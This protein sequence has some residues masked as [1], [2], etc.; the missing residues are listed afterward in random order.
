MSLNKKIRQIQ[1]IF[2]FT[3][4]KPFNLNMQGIHQNHIDEAISHESS[5][6]VGDNLYSLELLFKTYPSCIDL[7]YID[8]PYNT[9]SS[10]L[11]HDKRRTVCDGIFGSH[12]AWM[13]FMLPRLVAAQELLKPTGVIA[14]SIDDYEYSYLR[15]LMDRIF[16]ESNF[17]GNIVVCRSKNG[18]GSKKNI[19]SNHEYLMVYGKSNLAVLKGL[20][21]DD[22]AYTKSDEFGRYK[23]NGLFRKKGEA[24]LRTD[25]PNMFYPLFFDP[26][27]GKVKTEKTE[28]WNVALPIDSKGI[29]RRWLWSKQTATQRSKELYSSKKGVIYVKSYADT[30]LEKRKKIRTLW[31][32]TTFYTER[33]TNELTEIFGEKI[34]DT[35]KP[36]G[37]IETII[38]SMA[39]TDAKILDFFAGSGTTAHAA[40]KLNIADGGTRKTIL[41]ETD[42]SI[43]VKHLAYKAGYKTISQITEARLS[44][45]KKENSDFSYCVIR[46]NNKSNTDTKCSKIYN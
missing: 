40:E 32:E 9:G 39:S 16:G 42:D 12:G 37:L 44:F 41:M 4:E 26:Y 31:T 6:F 30:T 14:I 20:P 15:L 36:I 7:C 10:F 13:N 45:I 24:S 28:G 23:V 2:G 3:E 46:S 21:D 5:L 8:P 22:S 27:S 18:T 11:Y 43:P 19:A 34:F 17:I 25:R 33:A 35:P 1:K 29:E 38:D